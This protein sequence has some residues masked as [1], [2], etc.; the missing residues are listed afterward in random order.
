M[1][2][3][4]LTGGP[5]GL[6]VRGSPG[7]DAPANEASHASDAGAGFVRIGWFD[8][9]GDGHIDQRSAIAGGDA[10]LLLP[11]TVKVL[12]YSR[13]VHHLRNAPSKGADEVASKDNTA[14][15]G[16]G[17]VASTTSAASAP[18]PVAAPAGDVQT[19]QAIDAYQRYG[20]PSGPAPSDRAVA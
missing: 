12:T 20:Q 13:T 18:A 11:H 1:L 14:N 3:R 17:T 8:V 15:E 5:D 4:P 6:P 7:S 16:K 10:T 9:N 19:R 2:T